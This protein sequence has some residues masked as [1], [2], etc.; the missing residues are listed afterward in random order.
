MGN[1]FSNKCCMCKTN[2]ATYHKTITYEIPE[3]VCNYIIIAKIKPVHFNDKLIFYNRCT[4]DRSIKIAEYNQKILSDYRNILEFLKK[5][6][7]TNT[8]DRDFITDIKIN[9]VSY[10]FYACDECIKYREIALEYLHRI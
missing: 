7:S 6:P 2:K 5:M 3:C 4:C 9:D 1:Y 8:Y 10:N